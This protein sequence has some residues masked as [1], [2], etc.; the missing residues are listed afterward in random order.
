MID[1]NQAREEFSNFL[2]E[3]PSGRWRLDAALAH[4]VFWAYRRGL[5]DG[6]AGT[7]QPIPDTPT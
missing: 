1:L 4:V 2:A 7:P 3:D 6:A 5:E